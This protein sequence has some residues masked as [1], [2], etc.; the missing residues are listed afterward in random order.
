MSRVQLFQDKAQHELNCEHRRYT[1]MAQGCD[2]R[3]V[4]ADLVKHVKS[5]HAGLI[6]SG[7]EL[8]VSFPIQMMANSSRNYVL[9]AFDEMFRVNFQRGPGASL[10]HGLVIYLGPIDNARNYNFSFKVIY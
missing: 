7:N 3:G 2:W 4:H 5:Q 10:V 8:L 9:Y 1:C 6:H